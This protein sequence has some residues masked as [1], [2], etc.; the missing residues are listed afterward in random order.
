MSGEP[1]TWNTRRQ[2]ICR[3]GA[4]DGTVSHLKGGPSHP[5]SEVRR[6]EYQELSVE[7]A[8]IS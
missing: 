3:A 8:T 1:G 5:L 4:M 7:R 6:T 2:G